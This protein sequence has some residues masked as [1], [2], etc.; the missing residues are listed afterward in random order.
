MKWPCCASQICVQSTQDTPTHSHQKWKKIVPRKK[1]HT[2]TCN[3]NN[4]QITS[5]NSFWPLPQSFIIYKHKQNHPQPG[6]Q[7]EKERQAQETKNE[8]EH[9]V[10]AK[11]NSQKHIVQHS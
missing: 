4:K 6:L 2:T 11:K 5:S 10:E 9:A 1:T 7:D 3:E 8:I